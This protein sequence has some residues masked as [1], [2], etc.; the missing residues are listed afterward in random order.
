[1]GYHNGSGTTAGWKTFMQNNGNFYLSGTGA[2]GL[3]WDGTTLNVVGNGTFTGTITS[4]LGNIGGWSIN[5]GSLYSSNNAIFLDATNKKIIINDTANVPRVIMSQNSAF[6]SFSSGSSLSGTFSGQLYNS[7]PYAPTS[8]GSTL[9]DVVVPLGT[10]FTAASGVTYQISAIE[11]S[12]TGNEAAAWYDVV[13]IGILG[14]QL[15]VRRTTSPFTEYVVFGN[16]ATVYNGNIANF[17]T[18]WNGATSFVGDGGT[19]ELKVSVTLR[20]FGSNSL[21]AIRYKEPSFSW[22]IEAVSAFTEIIPAGI[23]T[24]NSS[25]RYV[26]MIRGSAGTTVMLDV[27]GAITATDNITAYAS[28]E[29]LKENIIKIDNPL[30]RVMQLQ[31][32]HY[33]W[34]SNTIELGF[35]PSQMSD[36]GVLAQDVQRVLPNAVK[37]APFD[38]DGENNS[39]SGQNYLTV[40]YEKIVPL[41]IEAIKELKEQIDELKINK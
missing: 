22:A 27:G 19:Y 41:L 29:R 37:I 32:V 2:N 18:G 10:T 3:F 17:G 33:D 23:Q 4:T 1:M 24:G 20:S 38:N 13:D 6:T 16:S 14:Y 35:K 34:K 21:N 28:D 40:Q 9:S 12:G 8:G 25:L 26:K 36:T 39:K 5:P 31:G 15:R 7:G 11:S 30:D